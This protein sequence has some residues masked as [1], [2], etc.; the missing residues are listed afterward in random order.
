MYSSEG[1]DYPL[2]APLL[3]RAIVS[4]YSPPLQVARVSGERTIEEK[5]EFNRKAARRLHRL[6]VPR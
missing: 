1:T 2:A 5:E 4:I 6:L 3:P